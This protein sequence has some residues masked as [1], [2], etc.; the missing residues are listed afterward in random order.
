MKLAT[1]EQLQYSSRID[2]FLDSLAERNLTFYA[3]DLLEQRACQSLEELG[4]AVVR[5]SEVCSCM[6][7]PLRENIKAV[8]RAR[9]GQVVQD[10]RLSPMA[11]MLLLL[12]ADSRNQLVAQ[13]QVELVK[14]AL[15]QE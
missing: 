14:R 6:Q 7:L 8:Y 5:A 2:G 13:L 11:Y 10:W 4:Q 3:S 1:L 15:Q 9:N 12:N